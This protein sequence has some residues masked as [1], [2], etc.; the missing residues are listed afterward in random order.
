MIILIAVIIF[1]AHF[2]QVASSVLINYGSWSIE[3]SLPVALIT[4][5]IV[6]LLLYLLIRFIHETRLWPQRLRLWGRKRKQQKMLELTQLGLTELIDAKWRQAEQNLEKAS[7][8]S[9]LPLINYLG[10]AYAAHEQQAY[11]RRDDYLKN[12]NQ[13]TDLSALHISLL[14]AK[15]QIADRAWENAET[16]VIE[17]YQHHPKHPEVLRLLANIYQHQHNWSGL[18]KLLPPLQKQRLL[19]DAEYQLLAIKTY[20]GLLRQAAD[21]KESETLTATWRQVPPNLHTKLLTLYVELLVECKQDQQAM[22]LI[23]RFLKQQWNPE[24]LPTYAKLN[25]TD[26]NKQLAQAESWLKKQGESEALLWCLGMLCYRCELW[27]KAKDYLTAA[28]NLKPTIAAHHALAHVS[29]A[30]KD[31]MAALYHYRQGL[32]M[33]IP[34]SA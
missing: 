34:L 14:Q 19:P 8:H 27:G 17:L 22:L 20:Q 10:A 31:P 12:L 21:H 33:A 2:H 7:T 4:L 23:E 11:Q 16:H 25:N 9:P 5:L 18:Q 3:T 30:L 1:G 28:V 15:F 6:F 32:D 26:L 13:K 29:E 24:L